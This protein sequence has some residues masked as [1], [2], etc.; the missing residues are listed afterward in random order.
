S[1]H[2]LAFALEAVGG[3]SSVS[4]SGHQAVTA[5]EPASTPRWTWM[6]IATVATVVVAA[7]AGAWIGRR[8]SSAQET[9]TASP[10]VFRQ[11]TFRR[12]SIGGA[13]FAPDGRTVVYSASWDGGDSRLYLT[14]PESPGATPLALPTA[15][16]F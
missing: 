10:P 7:I 11:L 13:R 2:D 16:L 12:G 1:A 14:R 5:A 4:S 6:A 15:V 3:S 8:A 9:A